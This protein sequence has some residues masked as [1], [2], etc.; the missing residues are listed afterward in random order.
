MAMDPKVA[1]HRHNVANLRSAFSPNQLRALEALFVQAD[2]N[3][4]E[5]DPLYTVICVVRDA[6]K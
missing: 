4:E 6:A 3:R 1:R 2:A 5:D